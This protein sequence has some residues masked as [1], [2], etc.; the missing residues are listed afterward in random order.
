M[1][2]DVELTRGERLR[3]QLCA[4]AFALAFTVGLCWFFENL[5]ALAVTGPVGMAWG[6]CAESIALWRK[7]RR[8]RRELLPAAR[9]VQAGDVG[10]NVR[11]LPPVHG[12]LSEDWNLETC[13]CTEASYASRRK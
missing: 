9:V 6:P 5:A 8:E 1:T 13:T 10:R 4:Y 3:A 11:A 12:H 2:T 7:R